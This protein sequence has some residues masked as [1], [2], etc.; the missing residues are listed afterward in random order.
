ME[1]ADAPI[2]RTVALKLLLEGAPLDF[3]ERFHREGRITG[4]LEHPN[5]VPVHEVG[6]LPGTGEVFI[7][8]KRITGRDMADVIADLRLGKGGEVWT[9]RRLVEAFRDVCRAV[10]YAHSKGVIHRDLKPSNVMLGEFGEVLVVDWG[11]AKDR[12]ESKVESRESPG[13]LD[14]RP[15]T[16]DPL[17][18]L[19][20]DV[21]G[22]PEYMP[23]EQAEG[24]VDEVDA[25]SDVYS[26]GAILY[27]ILVWRP[28]HVG[29]STSEILSRVVSE[30]VRAPSTVFLRGRAGIPRK[31][32]RFEPAAVPLD[33]EAVCMKALSRDKE[34]RHA[35]GRELAADI[36]QWLEGAKERE[37]A[38]RQSAARLA[39]AMRLLERVRTLRREVAEADAEAERISQSIQAWLPAEKKRPVWEAEDRFKSLQDDQAR[40][41]AQASAAFEEAFRL[42]PLNEDARE[43]RCVLEAE[44]FLEAEQRR[45]SREMIASRQALEALDR[46]GSHRGRLDAS[47]HVS[48]RTST[49]RC[50]CLKPG[51]EGW[52]V[53]YGEVPAVVWRDGAPDPGRRPQDRDSLVPSAKISPDGVRGA[54]AR[55]CPTRDLAGVGV[56]IQR[57]EE[58]DRRMVAVPTGSGGRTPVERL[59][60]PQGSYRA[61]FRRAGFVEACVPFVVTRGSELD[62]RV[63][64]YREEEAPAGFRFVPG[65]EFLFGD[66]EAG[67]E[68]PRL[69]KT[70]DIFMAVA[71]VTCAEYVEFLDDL[72]TSGRQE[73][74]LRR[75]LREGN[76][77]F[78]ESKGGKFA[79][80]A[81][82]APVLLRLQP[83]FPALGMSWHDAVAFAAWRSKRDRRVYRLPHEEEFEW[84]ARGA[85]Q[86]VYPWGNAADPAFSNTQL[87]H[88]EGPQPRAPGSF[89]ADESPFGVLDLA[90]NAPTW[91][92]N[93]P[94]KPYRHFCSLRGGSFRGS[95]DQAK[96]PR[97]QGCE[98]GIVHRQFGFRLCAPAFGPV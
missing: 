37:R 47:G 23:P 27:E 18:T 8:M 95:M 61:L 33:L 97:I 66:A 34:S 22:T 93:A 36:D 12:R 73:E 5:I 3:V 41:F 69:A 98:P 70:L 19:D 40:S 85:D 4:R 63:T 43:G 10:A 15:S 60:L 35:D 44:R 39:E 51:P 49:H 88:A 58:R 75:Q 90:G 48:L 1:A 7:A 64:M 84:A 52:R 74:A 16:L 25:R 54:H 89:P 42:N 13:T 79:Y 91:C 83:E 59:E 38:E 28:P 71:P 56:E 86:R 2:G 68:P 9:Q 50:E 53:S 21:F 24:K 55:E 32:P 72:C 45:D 80:P 29:E 62:F 57:F 14:S 78:L 17:L 65:G 30:P 96:S 31:G 26:L 20:G 92:W 94:R 77:W 67:G 11:L 87:S 6:A 82:G 81:A 46:T 76:A